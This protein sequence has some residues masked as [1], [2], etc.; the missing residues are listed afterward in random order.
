METKKKKGKNSRPAQTASQDQWD[1]RKGGDYKAVKKKDKSE[2]L[3]RTGKHAWGYNLEGELQ[4]SRNRLAKK[5]KDK[6]AKK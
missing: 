5:L 6:R 2:S 4:G 1:T 3:P